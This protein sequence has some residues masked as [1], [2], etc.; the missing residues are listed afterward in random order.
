MS[1][2][3]V[4]WRR[5]GRVR[6]HLIA[7]LYLCG[8]SGCLPSS[9]SSL[10]RAAELYENGRYR[11]AVAEYQHAIATNESWAPPHLGLGN[12]LRALGDRPAALSAY[13]RAVDLSPDYA[14]A[15]IA[16]A[17]LLM[18][19]GRW[20]DS[21]WQLKAAL[22][23]LPKDGRLHA[24]LGLALTKQG[25]QIEALRAF[26]RSSELCERCMTDQEAAAYDSVKR[27]Q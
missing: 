26:E 20:G 14:E 10:N 6:L 12:A 21:E 19:G 2:P 4:M 25:R 13:E 11:E 18:E 22:K 8:A 3:G 1:R 23:E 7:V 5:A 27:S 15:Q 17:G 24:L 9:A 16:L